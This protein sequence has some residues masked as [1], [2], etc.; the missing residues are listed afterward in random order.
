MW[1]A[2]FVYL[3][4]TACTP[5]E[6][7]PFDDQIACRKWVAREESRHPRFKEQMRMPTLEDEVVALR[8]ILIEVLRSNIGS[9]TC[10][11]ISGGR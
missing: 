1:V 7:G 2:L 10:A 4:C 11:I 5:F 9:G 6:I 8:L 3:A